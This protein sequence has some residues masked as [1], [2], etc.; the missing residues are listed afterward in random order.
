MCR[1][2]FWLF[3]FCSIFIHVLLMVVLPDFLGNDSGV[4][5]IQLLASRDLQLDV[6]SKNREY[7]SAEP[8]QEKQ[9]STSQ[10]ALL[11][12]TLLKQKMA[13]LSLGENLKTPSP[14][15]PAPPTPAKTSQKEKF[16]QMVDSPFYRELARAFAESRRL[17]GYHYP[18]MNA[19][20]AASPG[21]LKDEV[22]RSDPGTDRILRG[23]RSLGHGPS[24]P[25]NASKKPGIMGPAA[26]R[27]LTFVPPPPVVKGEGEAEVEM[28]FWIRANG[29]V[30]GVVPVTQSGDAALEEMATDYLRQW[31]F[32]SLPG[33]EP[34]VD[35]WGTVTVRFESE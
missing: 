17:G 24:A 13:E 31:R 9:A 1:R 30:G 35:T 27:E 15:V 4:I 3:L 10:D 23:L 14:N 26:Q 18:D 11:D 32:R 7:S 22:V 6:L 20:I 19:S 12:P 25:G 2:G 29:T 34:Q 5:L 16:R 33:S 28:R 8:E 21:R